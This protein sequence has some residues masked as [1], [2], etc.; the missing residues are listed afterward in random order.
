MINT[1]CFQKNMENNQGD[2]FWWNLWEVIITGGHETK[3][4]TKFDVLL[5]NEDGGGC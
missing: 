1:I 2:T 5:R 4:I 3:K